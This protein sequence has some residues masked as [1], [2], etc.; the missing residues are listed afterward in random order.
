MIIRLSA[1]FLRRISDNR[2]ITKRDDSPTSFG[3]FSPAPAEGVYR[4]IVNI[5]VFLVMLALVA[6]F[7]WLFTRAWKSKRWYVKFPGL[8]LAG[9]LTLLFVLIAFIYGKGMLGLYRPYPVAEVNVA[10]A[11]GSAPEKIAR[12]E[13]V[14][15]LRCAQCHTV[16]G[17]LPLSGG[18]NLSEDAGI[19][20]GDLYPPNLTPAGRI[21]DL[22]DSDIYRIIRTGINPNGKLT[23]MATVG[24]HK[25]SD[26]DAQS[27]IAYLRSAPPVQNATPPVVFSPL[28]VML[29]GAD[30]FPIVAPP[31]VQ[32]VSAPPK[33]A[34]K[35]YGRYVVDFMHCEACHGP[36]LSGDGGPFAPPGAA[37]LTVVLPK[38]SK[39]DFFQAMRTGV[40]STG[41]RLSDKMPWK[42]VAQL[43]DVELEAVYAYLHGL[44]PILPK[45]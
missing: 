30:L 17:E 25:L 34:T 39:D 24:V 15:A 26:E 3:P 11:G 2:V 31:T 18:K 4:M 43:D 38:W 12:G 16:T 45:K 40:D 19:A 6:L 22:S 5:L 1:C 7:A 42:F 41:H 33:A 21:K 10:I 23:L 44:T 14:A 28:A 29:F 36:T 13:H 35:E 20:L 9:L 37:N 8:I 27:V 32:S